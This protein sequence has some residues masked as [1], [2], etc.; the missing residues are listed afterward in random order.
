M[1]RRW[2]EVLA[3]FLLFILVVGAVGLTMRAQQRL[4]QQRS[5]AFELQIL[6]SAVALYKVV[7]RQNPPSLVALA[8]ETYRLPGDEETR[9]YLQASPLER[10]GSVRDPFG[11]VYVYEAGSGWIRSSTKGYEFW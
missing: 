7:K 6:R 9:R 3:A 11:T 2:S 10:D 5:L 8:T 1:S 4:A